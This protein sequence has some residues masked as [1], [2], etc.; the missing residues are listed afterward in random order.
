VS[1]LSVLRVLVVVDFGVVVE[2]SRF[3]V[4]LALSVKLAKKKVVSLPLFLF[5]VQK[6]SL[7]VLW[8]KGAKPF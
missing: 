5:L 2:K 4:V 3:L 1:L 6:L 7:T 8:L